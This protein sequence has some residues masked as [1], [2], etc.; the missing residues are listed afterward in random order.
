MNRQEQEEY[1]LLKNY[2]RENVFARGTLT[3]FISTY[4]DMVNN[5][6]V[7]LKIKGKIEKHHFQ[8]KDK[9]KILCLLHIDLV[10]KLL[11]F[12][13]D[14]AIFAESF[15][16]KRSFYSIVSS[17]NKEDDVGLL[18][19]KFL[20]NAP[21]FSF[22]EI[23]QI[24]SYASS[25]VLEL[26]EK[27]KEV[28]DKIQ[29]GNIE[30]MRRVF[31]DMHE[32]GKSHHLIFKRFKHAGFPV[33]L[34]LESEKSTRFKDYETFFAVMG[35]KSITSDVHYFPLS[36]KIREIIELMINSIQIL[37]Q[38]IITNKIAS[39]ERESPGI[40]PTVSHQDI[41]K[42]DWE[43]YLQILEKFYSKFPFKEIPNKFMLPKVNAEQLS[44]Y[45]N[46]DDFLKQ[47]YQRKIEQDKAQ[48]KF[49]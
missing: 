14:Y 7:F 48:E 29:H 6:S 35:G 9:Q 20:E 30:D 46:L 25:D 21:N 16:Q 49:K 45:A 43:L 39:M 28:V 34:G 17:N 41:S 31:K 24:L 38:D 47:A 5:D 3:N 23:Q 18:I 40:F 32:F 37:L 1:F 11:L 2:T 8:G 4:I 33:F 12:I 10:S 19:K 22:E 42:E 15:R 26:S 44:W 36:N 13:E 27:E